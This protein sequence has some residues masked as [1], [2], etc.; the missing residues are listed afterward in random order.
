M[1]VL[2][3]D[4]KIGEHARIPIVKLKKGQELKLKAIAKKGI[5]KEHA[6]WGPCSVATFQFDPDIQI[7]PIV[8]SELDYAQRKDWYGAALSYS[9]LLLAARRESSGCLLCSWAGALTAR[10]QGGQ[11]PDA[12]L[13]DG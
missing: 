13:S 11:L 4:W 6:K 8:M 12:R 3:V 5:A 7:N 10:L 2:P 9:L 1:D